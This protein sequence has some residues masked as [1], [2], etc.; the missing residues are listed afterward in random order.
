MGA[1]HCAAVK[2]PEKDW[3]VSFNAPKTVHREVQRWRSEAHKGEI[4]EIGDGPIDSGWIVWLSGDSGTWT[5]PPGAHEIYVSAI[6]GHGRRTLGG[7][8][9]AGLATY[10]VP[11]EPGEELAFEVGV[12]AMSWALITGVEG[13]GG[14]P[15]GGPGGPFSVGGG[16]SSRL[17]RL[18]GPPLV[19]APGE[20]GLN[21]GAPLAWQETRQIE[22][23][24]EFQGSPLGAAPQ[25]LPP[26]GPSV[27]LKLYPDFNPERRYTE[28][29][30]GGP[31]SGRYGGSGAPNYT[32]GSGNRSGGGGGGGGYGGGA[33]GSTWD[34]YR[35]MYGASDHLGTGNVSTAGRPGSPHVTPTAEL[36]VDEFQVE[37]GANFPP[38]GPH[39][40]VS[41]G[42]PMVPT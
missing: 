9:S 16:G 33:G 35:I 4:V 1:P 10:A 38:S 25:N 14:W 37:L 2:A 36:L 40:F 5:V 12:N 28:Y 6:G 20:G 41:W 22:W 26:W 32:Q 8:A 15:D 13:I 30:A 39:I 23:Q 31:G 3:G 24:F 19:I 29:T 34:A 21:D 27:G 42:H 11:V 7:S 18:A 17:T